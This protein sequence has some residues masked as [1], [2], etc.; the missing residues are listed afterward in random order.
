MADKRRPANRPKGR[1]AAITDGFYR[2]MI[3]NPDRRIPF[4]LVERA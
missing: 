3:A 1:R 2:R 4:V